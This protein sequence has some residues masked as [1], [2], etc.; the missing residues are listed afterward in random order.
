[1]ISQKY[2]S[3]FSIFGSTKINSQIENFLG[4]TNIFF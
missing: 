3:Y 2:F 1:M 4:L